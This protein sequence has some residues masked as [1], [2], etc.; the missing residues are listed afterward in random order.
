MPV[1]GNNTNVLTFKVEETP[2]KSIGEA[3]AICLIN[4]RTLAIESF[5][6]LKCF[7]QYWHHCSPKIECEYYLSAAPGIVKPVLRGL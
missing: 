1:R 7:N 6:E 5:D 3:I 2:T 4:A